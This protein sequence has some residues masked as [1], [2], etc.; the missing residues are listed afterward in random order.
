MLAGSFAPGAGDGC[1]IF[2]VRRARYRI[3]LVLVH[4]ARLFPVGAWV[5]FRLRREA[6]TILGEK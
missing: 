1:T 4:L 3:L 5:L 2:R 6:Y